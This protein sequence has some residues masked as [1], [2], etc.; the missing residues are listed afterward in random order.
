MKDAAAILEGFIRL[1]C[2]SGFPK[3]VFCDQESSILKVMREI[4]VNLR[5]L[6]H[7]LYSEHGILFD[8][9]AVGGHDQHGKVER[10]IRSMQ[11]SLSELGLD[12]MRLHA[13][14]IQTLCKQ[15]ENA[16]NNLPLGYRF[17][18]SQDNTEVL[19][20]LVPN[21]LRMGKINSRSLEGPVKLSADNKKML[22][23]IQKKYEAWYK[24]W[25]QVYVPKLMATKSGFKNS[26]D[27]AV[28]DIVYFEKEESALS[29]PWIMGVIDQV[30]R[31][32]DGIIRRAI[33]KYRNFKEEFDRFTDRSVRKLIKIYSVDDPDLQHDLT[34]VQA[35]IDE[36]LGNGVHVDAA[37][38]SMEVSSETSN[39]G[40]A[41]PNALTKS[42]FL[43]DKCQCCCQAHCNVSLHNYSG[44]K[45]FYQALPSMEDQVISLFSREQIQ[46]ADM[47][48]FEE[49]C[50]KD[51]F[52]AL[53]M[54]V[55]LNL[56]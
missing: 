36:L 44:T 33:V 49:I 25:C 47:E 48:E 9:C 22:G 50:D 51:N 46:E 19:K 3:Y 20:L 39:Q 17:D 26:R 21:M 45:T 35:R 29:S 28:E 15:V 38:T 5:D 2:E 4:Q 8:T 37:S 32:R 34:K 24:I 30:V 13:M 23:D 52:T 31:G 55:G 18:R 11:D 16:Y 56:D 42:K 40:A 27:L 54:S 1:S 10:T 7:R 43:Q 6:A 41:Q 14:G 12:K 53:I